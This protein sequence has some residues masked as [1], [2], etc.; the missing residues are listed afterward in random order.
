M[1]KGKGK[2]VSAVDDEH[3][4][5]DLVGNKKRKRVER[6]GL[7]LAK[8]ARTEVVAQSTSSASIQTFEFW[9]ELDDEALYSVVREPQAKSLWNV[10]MLLAIP[11]F[12]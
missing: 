7:K 8:K 12:L 1:N 9:E 5:V 4:N 10:G 2:V 6:E 11:C 3:D